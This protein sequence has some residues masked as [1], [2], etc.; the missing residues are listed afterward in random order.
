MKYRQALTKVYEKYT[1]VQVRSMAVAFLERYAAKGR[2]VTA[3]NALGDDADASRLL[4]ESLGFVEGEHFTVAESALDPKAKRFNW[5]DEG[6]KL[7]S[8]FPVEL[9]PS[10]FNAVQYLTILKEGAPLNLIDDS[11]GAERRETPGN[12]FA[13]EIINATNAIAK[14]IHDLV[15]NPGN[16]LS[17]TYVE[18]A[19]AWANIQL[20]GVEFTGNPDD[21]RTPIAPLGVLEVLAKLEGVEGLPEEFVFDKIGVSTEWQMARAVKAGEKIP[22]AKRLNCIP[23]AEQ[24]SATSPVSGYFAFSNTEFKKFT[25]DDKVAVWVQ[26]D[27]P[28]RQTMRALNFALDAE[29]MKQFVEKIVTNGYKGAKCR[30]VDTTRLGVNNHALDCTIP[31][32]GCDQVDGEDPELTRRINESLVRENST[33]YTGAYVVTYKGE[34]EEPA[35]A[36]W[37]TTATKPVKTSDKPAQPDESSAFADGLTTSEIAEE[38]FALT[39]G[40]PGY[41]PADDVMYQSYDERLK[42]FRK[43]LVYFRNMLAEFRGD[44]DKILEACSPDNPVFSRTNSASKPFTCEGAFVNGVCAA[45][46]KYC[47][48]GLEFV[49]TGPHK[50]KMVAGV[51]SGIQTDKSPVAGWNENIQ[52]FP[53]QTATPWT[54]EYR[55]DEGFAKQTTEFLKLLR[56][57]PEVQLKFAERT[58][59]THRTHVI[60]IETNIK[61]STFVSELIRTANV[62]ELESAFWR[63]AYMTLVLRSANPLVALDNEFYWYGRDAGLYGYN[64]TNRIDHEMR[65]RKETLERQGYGKYPDPAVLKTGWRED[66][67]GRMVIIFATQ[68]HRIAL[69]MKTIFRYAMKLPLPGAHYL[70]R[71]RRPTTVTL[72]PEWSADTTYR[73]VLGA[74]VSQSGFEDDYRETGGACGAFGALWPTTACYDLDWDEIPP[75]RWYLSDDGEQY[76]MTVPVRMPAQ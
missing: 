32:I 57:N 72:N 35:Y 65:D 30:L 25:G 71:N 16:T 51:W 31:E 50:D 13:A 2:P 34:L 68:C 22:C 40:T 42:K 66:S 17:G 1:D 5:T 29:A 21:C 18:A 58:P 28:V 11:D 70:M 3:W 7:L 10:R 36:D 73:A 41:Q 14:R 6:V 46:R 37:S 63:L 56:K 19:E 52:V 47:P 26:F 38:W 67:N 69:G 75:R 60:A 9:Q 27:A 54:Y 23:I 53:K 45:L 61:A 62:R 44:K 8:L 43:N 74:A 4:I 20:T 39:H 33:V 64:Y 12:T 59:N 24:R 76:M 15:A 48:S 49:T 55:H